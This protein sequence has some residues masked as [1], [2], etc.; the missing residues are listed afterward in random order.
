MCHVVLYSKVICFSLICCYTSLGIL[1][2]LAVVSHER[3]QENWSSFSKL[4]VRN[5]K[6]ADVIRLLNFVN[7]GK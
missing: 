6:H 1:Y 4:K 3:F 2:Y 5:T 7:K